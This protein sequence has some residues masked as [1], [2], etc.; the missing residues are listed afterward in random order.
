[1]KAAS[2]ERERLGLVGDSLLALADESLKKELGLAEL[3]V[4]SVAHSLSLDGHGFAFK[5]IEGSVGTAWPPGADGL[6]GKEARR[7]L[8]EFGPNDANLYERGGLPSGSC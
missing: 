8:A 2:L 4:H 7:R 3:R 5:P 1:M 6:S